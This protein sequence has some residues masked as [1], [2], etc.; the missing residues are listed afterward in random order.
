[1]A[2]LTL[3]VVIAV[4]GCLL[5]RESRLQRQE[6]VLIQLL[7]MFAPAIVRARENPCEM[8]AWSDAARGARTSF[9]DAFRKLEAVNGARYPFSHEMVEEAHA[10]WTT[11]WLAWEQKHDL[12]YKQKAGVVEQEVD[13]ADAAQAALTRTRLEAIQDEKLQKYQQRYEHYVKV[14]KALAALDEEVSS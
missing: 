7:K 14:S 9:P 13:R 8:V 4:V 2:L 1:V 12:E 11:Q 10:Q 3:A 5:I 6:Q